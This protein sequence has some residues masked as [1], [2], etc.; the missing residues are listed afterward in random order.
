MNII[1]KFSAQPDHEKKVKVKEPELTE[2]W[3]KEDYRLFHKAFKKHKE[4]YKAIKN[5]VKSKSE[6]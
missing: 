6:S 1:S 5:A 4:D 3:T 2:T